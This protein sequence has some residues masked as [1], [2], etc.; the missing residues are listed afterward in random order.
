MHSCKFQHAS[1]GSTP[2]RFR[3]HVNNSMALGLWDIFVGLL[4]SQSRRRRRL[5]F[6]FAIFIF[7][8]LYRHAD[9]WVGNRAN[10]FP[11]FKVGYGRH[12]L[13]LHGVSTKHFAFYFVPNRSSVTHALTSLLPSHLSA[14]IAVFTNCFSRSKALLC[15]NH[16]HI[17]AWTV[18]NKI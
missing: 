11:L 18:S 4:S 7:T 16:T 8:L 5:T 1:W 17:F 9:G 15:R 14:S 3:G 6:F 12:G 2:R 10:V 13:S